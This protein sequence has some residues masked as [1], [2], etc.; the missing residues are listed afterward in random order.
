MERLFAQIANV[1]KSDPGNRGLAGSLPDTSLSKLA[2]ELMAARRVIIV[3]GF[4]IKSCSIG[5]TDGPCGA[6]N[7]AYALTHLEKEVTIVT[8]VY[9]YDMVTAACALR[10]PSAQM[11]CVP[12]KGAEAFCRCLLDEIR[13]THVI[14]IERPGKSFTGHFYNMRGEIIDDMVADTELLLT[15]TN[16]VTIGIGDGGNEL[17]MGGAPCPD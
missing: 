11:A 7:I 9:S 5:E 15:G 8:D 3:T 17:G 2:E 6:A 16:A 13:P 1:L 14:A 12:M 10:A 4:P